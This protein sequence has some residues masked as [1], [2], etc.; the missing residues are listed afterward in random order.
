MKKKVE[1][2]EGKMIRKERKKEGKGS[3]RKTRK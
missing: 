3:R 1:K 2:M